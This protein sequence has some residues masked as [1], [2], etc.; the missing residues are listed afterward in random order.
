MSD[1]KS[2]SSTIDSFILSVFPR[3]ST[4][5]KHTADQTLS[6]ELFPHE[7]FIVALATSFNRYTI[8]YPGETRVSRM[9]WSAL[10]GYLAW[11][12]YDYWILICVH[13]L[14]FSQYFFEMLKA[15]MSNNS[16]VSKKNWNKKL[17][18]KFCRK[19]VI[20]IILF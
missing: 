1:A 14:S 13:L 5:L 15:K 17:W 6:T 3:V 8:K 11:E 19:S 16:K 12:N 4:H 7:C 18:M 2:I 10:L 20:L 9:F